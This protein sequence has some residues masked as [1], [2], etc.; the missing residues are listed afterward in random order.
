M[1]TPPGDLWIHTQAGV[2]LLPAFEVKKSEAHAAY[3]MRF[4]KFG[5][6]DGLPG[7]PAQETPLPSAGRGSDGRIWLATNNGV[8]WVA[9]AQL[10][11]NK[12]A[13]L[14]SIDSI[15]A[16]GKRH[17]ASEGL[18]LPP[19]TQNIKVR[20]A[21]LGPTLPERTQVRIRMSRVDRDWV[22]VGNVR[23]AGYT[24][25]GPGHYRFQVIDA[26]E[27]G[28]WNRIGA[29]VDFRI[30]PTFFQ[31]PWFIS[32]YIASAAFLIRVV[33][34]YRLRYERSLVADRVAARH[35][36]R[37]RIARELQ[38]TLLQGFQGLLLRMQ[39]WVSDPDLGDARRSETSR[40]IGQT[41]GLLI[42]GRDRIL[43]LRASDNDSRKL[44]WELQSFCARFATSHATRIEVIDAVPEL[45]LPNVIAG[46]VVSIA[47]EALLNA[48]KHAKSSLMEVRL[49]HLKDAVRL[50]VRD[51]GC[52]IVTEIVE[53]GGPK[54][55]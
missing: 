7:S 39:T 26:K 32:L 40:S 43:A 46:E 2:Y 6:L 16:D 17:R 33:F 27:D 45:M 29:T 13:P 28:V 24:R 4:R 35:A 38:D 15:C 12:L 11:S 31:T 48:I 42:Q 21:A 36:E 52:G 54:G 30:E 5:T 34:S 49:E 41:R 8:V 19:N 55:H 44:A 22:D 9:P 25:H 10:V 47:Q 51:D 20:F 23:E 53:H 1:P 3:G 50:T 37:D 14:V 18:K